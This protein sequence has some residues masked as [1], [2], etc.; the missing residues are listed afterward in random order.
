[1]RPVLPIASF[2][3]DFEKLDRLQ[4]FDPAVLEADHE[5]PQSVCDFLLALCLVQNDCKDAL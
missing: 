4:I 1:M 2:E 5:T 3:D